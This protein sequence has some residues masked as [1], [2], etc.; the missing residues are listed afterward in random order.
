MC[1]YVCKNCKILIRFSLSASQLN[2]ID[3][4]AHNTHIFKVSRYSFSLFFFL[5]I[6]KLKFQFFNKRKNNVILCVR[7]FEKIE[8]MPKTHSAKVKYIVFF[9]HFGSWIFSCFFFFCLTV[10]M[11]ESTHSRF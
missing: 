11:V 6:F 10:R 3:R 7:I 4:Y 5:F 1:V 8:Q 9:L 2:E